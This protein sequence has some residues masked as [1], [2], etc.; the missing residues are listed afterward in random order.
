MK[1]IEQFTDLMYRYTEEEWRDQVF[2]MAHDLGYEQML[3]AIFPNRNSPIEAEFAFLQSN[4]SS[5]WRNK[6]DAEKMGHFDPAIRH[7][8]S[9]SVPL[10]LSPDIFSTRKQKQIYEEASS[11]GIRSGVT[12]P[13][14][15]AKGELGI[16]HFVSDTKPGRHVQQATSRHLPELSYFRDFIFETAARFMQS[17]SLDEPTTPLTRR[18]LECL[19]WSVGGKSSWTI[20]QILRC[21][22]ATVNFHFNNIRR[23]LKA[24]TRQE[25]AIRAIRMGLVYPV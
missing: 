11:Y 14:H 25:A 8:M 7:C 24:A 18:E 1:S 6:Y 9:K 12:L 4:F 2:E 10:I 13:I 17:S 20:A 19:K 16:L 3:L 21:S 22:E 15:G 23:K 5:D